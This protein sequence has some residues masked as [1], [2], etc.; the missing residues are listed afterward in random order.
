MQHDDEYVQ[1]V[2]ESGERLPAEMC[3][4]GMSE[5]IMAEPVFDG[6]AVVDAQGE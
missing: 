3:E 1:A 6:K 2:I 4:P 5:E